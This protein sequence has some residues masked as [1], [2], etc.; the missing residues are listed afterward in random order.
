MVVGSV[1]EAKAAF[2]MVEAM[3]LA[4]LPH[5]ASSSIWETG[6]T[7]KAHGKLLGA[8][9]KR[10]REGLGAGAESVAAYEGGEGSGAA[11]EGA[12]RNV[13][14]VLAS[15]GVQ[16]QRKAAAETMVKL[17]PR[18]DFV[19]GSKFHWRF[20]GRC[21]S[22]M[23]Y[24]LW[25]KAWAEAVGLTMKADEAKTYRALIHR[26]ETRRA[27]ATGGGGRRK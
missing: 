22:A 23:G 12:L 20:A 1:E 4:M 16:L 2:G 3:S 26:A 13:V 11:V 6:T 14:E 25:A 24:K 18:I 5:L 9:A 7:A 17:G 19:L 8:T 27:L 21:I 15:A 10:L